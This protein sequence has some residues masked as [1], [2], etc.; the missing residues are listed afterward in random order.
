VDF[1][2]AVEDWAHFNTIK[3]RLIER[4]VFEAAPKAA[5]RLYYKPNPTSSGYPLDLIPFRGVEVPPSTIAWPPEMKVVMN[6]AGYEE[7]LETSQLVEVVPEFPVRVV[8]LPGLALLKLF[9][10][11]DRGSDDPKDA[12]D[13]ATLLRNYEFAE[14]LDRLYEEEF[15]TLDAVD[16]HVDL[17]FARLL[18]AD[19]RAIAAPATQVQLDALFND[20]DKLD[21]LAQHMTKALSG[22]DD[23][24]ET[25]QRLVDHFKAGA[26]G[27]KS[28]RPHE[29]VKPK[30]R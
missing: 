20:A 3:A 7:A 25:A 18:G 10:W 8:S 28:S 16:H 2:I 11:V 17:A 1:A 15:D 21:R 12:V 4:G 19:M 5:Q 14:G 26:L 29:D 24:F 30:F 6:V 23:A 9:A 27:E 22:V 13:L